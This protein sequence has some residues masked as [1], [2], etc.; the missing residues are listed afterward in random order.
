MSRRDLRGD[1][2][3]VHT[4][5]VDVS[6]AA[7]VAELAADRGRARRDPCRRAHR[8]CVARA[9]DDAA[10]RRHRRGRHRAHP[11]RVRAARADRHRGGLHREH[12]GHDDDAAARR[13]AAARDDTDR[14]ARGVAG[15]GSGVDDPRDR[16]RRREAGEPRTCA[17]RVDPVGAPRR[18]RRVDQPR[19]HLDADGAGRAR[20]PVRATSCAA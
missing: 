20:G 12:G 2:Y 15:A 19:H 5:R 1:G 14:R 16:V 13:A 18:A 6:S 9:G 4:V 11:R 8:G 3:D 17:G 7:D 10:D